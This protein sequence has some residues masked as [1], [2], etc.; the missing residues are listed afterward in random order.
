[1]PSSPQQMSISILLPA[2][3][4][5]GGLALA[6]QWGDLH[7]VQRSSYPACA[8]ALP[9]ALFSSSC[10]SWYQYDF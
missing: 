2:T 10:C 6:Q 4:R 7:A 3:L 8:L 9:A 5:M 1:M